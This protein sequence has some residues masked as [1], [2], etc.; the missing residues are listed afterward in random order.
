MGNNGIIPV[1]LEERELITEKG[2]V[3]RGFK[4]HKCPQK[5]EQC[6]VPD[7]ITDTCTSNAKKE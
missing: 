3:V 2:R 5:P 6:T 4:R 7:I 1:D